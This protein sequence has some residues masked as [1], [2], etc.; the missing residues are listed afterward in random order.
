MDK[1]QLTE[2]EFVKYM[3]ELETLNK[4]IR[5]TEQSFYQICEGMIYIKCANDGFDLALKLI[6][7]LMDDKTEWVSWFVYENEFGKRKLEAGYNN[8]LKPIT[9]AKQLYKLMV[10]K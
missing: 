1:K 3:S 7:K 4:E 10:E 8:N 6:A 9:T 2:K 5:K